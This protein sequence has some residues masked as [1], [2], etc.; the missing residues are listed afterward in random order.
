MFSPA[1]SDPLTQVGTAAL[2]TAMTYTATQTET[3]NARRN[4]LYGYLPSL[5]YAGGLYRLSPPG[6]LRWPTT[7]LAELPYDI[8]PS[9][10]R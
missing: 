7:A 4:R 2:N 10:R 6:R 5:Y 3:V 8:R 1:G 9:G